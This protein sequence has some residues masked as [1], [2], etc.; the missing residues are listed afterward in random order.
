MSNYTSFAGGAPVS[1]QA[2]DIIQVKEAEH[3]YTSHVSRTNATTLELTD[4]AITITAL[5]AVTKIIWE[6]SIKSRYIFR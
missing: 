2:G 1:V 3:Q 4:V 5:L 6:K